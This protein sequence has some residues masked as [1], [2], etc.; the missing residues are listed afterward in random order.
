MSRKSDNVLILFVKAPRLGAVKTR[1]QPELTADQ[2]LQL[3]QA[4]VEDLAH[5]FANLDFCDLKLFFYP[6]NAVGEMKTWLGDTF[7][8]YSQHGNDLGEKM[9]NAITTMLNSNYK[10]VVLTGSDIPT[11]DSATI[12]HA[13]S[14]LNEENIV[15]GPSSDGGYYLIGM[16][17]QNPEIFRQI[18]WSSG[19][20]LRQTIEKAKSANLKIVELEEK[21]DIDTY[22]DLCK[23]WAEVQKNRF[24]IQ[25]KTYQILQTLFNVEYLPQR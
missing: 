1:L 21:W 18:S 2:S 4:M 15:I 12:D 14:S 22:Q 25:P 20:V 16:K 8:Y 19:S 9:Q 7:E 5:Q 23:I 6:V 3:Y 10:K 13:F 11:L 17:K 24:S